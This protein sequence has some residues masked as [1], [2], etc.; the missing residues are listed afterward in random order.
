MG[1]S[2]EKLKPLIPQHYCDDAM[3]M[4]TPAVEQTI[5]G[6]LIYIKGVQRVSK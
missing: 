5:A 4:E 3:D 2:W 6:V 1:G